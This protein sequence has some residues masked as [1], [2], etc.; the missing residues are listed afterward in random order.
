[1]IVVMPDKINGENHSLD[2]LFLKCY[3]MIEL[4]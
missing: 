3:I 1:M 4:E 2:R